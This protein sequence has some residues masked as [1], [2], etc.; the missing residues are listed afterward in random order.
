[1]SELPPIFQRPTFARPRRLFL[2]AFSGPRNRLLPLVV[3]TGLIGGLVGAGYVEALR[4]LQHFLWPTH[5]ANWTHWPLLIAIGI[6]VALL[7]K[8][9]GDP[10]DT[11]LLVDNI[12]ITGGMEDVHNLRSLVPVSL[13]GIAVGG[14][15][16]PEAPL[17]QI[18]GTLGS[19]V[20]IRS[21]SDR[22]DRRILTIT[23]MAAG[24]TVL[25][26]A[27]LGS[28]VFALEI[29][30]RRGLEYY[31]ALLPACLGSAIGYAVYVAI[32]SLGLQ[33]IWRFPAAP[34]HI[35]T[36]DL[37]WAVLCGVAGAVV[38]YLFTWLSMFFRWTVRRLPSWSKPVVAGVALGGIAWISPYALTFSEA[39]LTH[40]GALNTIAVSTL[41]LAALGHLISAPVTMAGQWKGGFIIPL[42]FIG[43]CV[44]RAGGIQFGHGQDYVLWATACMV[45][46]NVGV[47][48]TP[49]GSTLVV[50]E[51]VGMRIIPT[52]LIAAIVSLF[53][54]SGANLLHSQRRREGAHGESSGDPEDLVRGDDGLANPHPSPRKPAGAHGSAVEAPS[55]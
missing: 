53:L 15:I 39:Q 49:L 41:L 32:T 23:G 5:Y 9:L 55:R 27:P 13:L 22:V 29:L 50:A 30:H 31:E 44:G 42:F 43:Y 26:G 36:S 46:C 12:H 37:G 54:T 25:F 38:A 11:E 4:G 14:G 19:W 48:K 45:A 18:T 7:V 8:L 2:E 6:A 3:A 47:T 33:P 10:G 40:I 28:A 20:G 1:V 16:G 35:H 24:F 51:M 34:M 17:T 52:L 21:D